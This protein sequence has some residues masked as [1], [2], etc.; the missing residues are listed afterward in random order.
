M[1]CEIT[2][3]KDEGTITEWEARYFM[4]SNLVIPQFSCLPKTHKPGNKI[5]PVVSNVNS[6]TSRKCEW[7]VKKF[8]ALKRTDSFSVRNS[9]E[10]AE[11]MSGT[12][13]GEDNLLVSFDVESLYP[14]VPVEEALVC[15][16]D[17]INSQ[18]ISDYEAQK[19]VKLTQLVFSHRWIQFNGKI[20][21]Q[22]KGLFIGNS[23]SPILAEV[24][25]GTIEMR[26]RFSM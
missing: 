1:R 24:F 9:F 12:S 25:M 21:R 5:R 11:R 14:S 10:L 15:F 6:P 23:L 26:F 8:R 17:W 2:T 18:E 7:L 20:F 13:I 19:Y 22:K 3:M 16:S 4:V